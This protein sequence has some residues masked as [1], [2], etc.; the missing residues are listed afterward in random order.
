[1]PHIDSFI[2]F[3]SSTP[4]STAISNND[5]IVLEEANLKS[6][7][8]Q[9][10]SLIEIV[11]CEKEV[12]LFYSA[13][14]IK[15]FLVNVEEFYKESY[16]IDIASTIN[17][18][19]Q[20]ANAINWQYNP[21]QDNSFQYFILDFNSLQIIQL[22]NHSINEGLERQL[23]YQENKVFLINHLA[24]NVSN[25]YVSLL[26]K[27][28]KSNDFPSALIIPL[29]NNV[30]EIDEWLT[31]N[32]KTRTFNLSPKHGENGKRAHPSNKGEEVSILECSKEEAQKL[33]E[34]AI[35]DVRIDKKRL[36]NYDATRDNYI[37]FYYEGENPQNQY[38]GF[39]ISKKDAAQK[40]PNT[41]LKRL[42]EK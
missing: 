42:N 12:N 31:E 28:T 33:L 23:T 15:D 7:L 34:N 36:Y 20:K 22:F 24:L 13:N 19:L 40:I 35:G 14:E 26:K 27:S 25:P 38:H 2:L 17:E 41:M 10:E 37:L 18:Y 9:L 4:S 39:H 6:F 8:S 1:M 29:K 3:P 16:L 32:R 5:E 11:G 30:K 21:T